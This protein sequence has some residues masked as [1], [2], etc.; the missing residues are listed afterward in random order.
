MNR[1]VKEMEKERLRSKIANWCSGPIKDLK[2]GV[3]TVS[4]IVRPVS[5]ALEWVQV[6]YRLNNLQKRITVSC[7]HGWPI[8]MSD[9]AQDWRI[10]YRFPVLSRIVQRLFTFSVSDLAAQHDPCRFAEKATRMPI[11]D[12]IHVAVWRFTDCKQLTSCL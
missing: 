2:W 10:Y 4:E 3:K 1:T 12:L 11:H 8:Q 6:S 9:W 7:K 5:N